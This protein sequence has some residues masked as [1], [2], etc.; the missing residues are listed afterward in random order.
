[1][2]RGTP[3][4]AQQRPADPTGFFAYIRALTAALGD[5]ARADEAMATRNGFIP[6]GPELEDLTGFTPDAVRTQ[7]STGRGALVPILTKFGN[8]LGVWEADWN[9]LARSQPSL[10][11]ATAPASRLRAAK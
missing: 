5:N 3:K 11:N 8:R 9:E 10:R 6:N 1:M 2:R 4:A 7:S